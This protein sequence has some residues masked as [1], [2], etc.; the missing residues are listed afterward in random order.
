M[1][2]FHAAGVQVRTNVGVSMRDNVRLSADIYL[3][4]DQPGP[5]PVI[6]C[7]MP[8]DNSKQADTAYYSVWLCV[9]SGR[10]PGPL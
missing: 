1:S 4:R 10:C 7:R 6:L 9:R 8:Y 2:V 3:P 5:F